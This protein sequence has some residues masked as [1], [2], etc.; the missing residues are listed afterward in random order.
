MSEKEFDLVVIGGGSAGLTAAGLA[1]SLGAKTALIEA[2]RPGGDCTWHGCVPSKALLHAAEI[3]STM[4]TGYPGITPATV[5]IDTAEVLREVRRVRA[6][7]YEESDA[8][9]VLESF[10]IN[11]LEGSAH[12]LDSHTV[13]LADGRSIKELSSKYFIIASGA[14]PTRLSVD[15]LDDE[16][17]LTTD[18]IFDLEELP[19]SLLIVGGG[20]VGLELAQALNRLGVTLHVVEKGKRPGTRFE[21]EHASLVIGVLED[22]GVTFHFGCEVVRGGE[23]DGRLEVVV[24]G[25]DQEEMTIVVDQLLT[26][27]GRTARTKSLGLE[28]AGVAYDRTGIAINH[29]CQTSQSHI[30]A[31]GDVAQGPDFTHVAED[32]AKTAVKRILL[33]VPGTRERDLVPEILYTSPEIARIGSLAADLEERGAHFKTIRFPYSRI[34]RARIIGANAGEIVIHYAP[35]SGKIL[36]GHIVGKEAGEILHE[37]VLAMAQGVTL[38]EI[39]STLHAYPTMAQGVRRAADQIY[40]QTGSTAPLKFLGSL[41]GYRGEVSDLIGGDEVV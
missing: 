33:K 28:A 24:S 15:G 31:C 11:V 5:E 9:T 1:A 7:I 26:A 18:S 25:E 39:S 35:L 34:D 23:R 32:M 37:L 19:D 2:A 22:E 17:I 20:P 38:R 29:S 12:F 6:T 10:G 14:E 36:G 3:A 4:M 41:F 16:I 21:P 13:A 8:P 27:I 30:Y 40:V